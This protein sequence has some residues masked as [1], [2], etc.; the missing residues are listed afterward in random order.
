MA[1]ERSIFLTSPGRC[2]THWLGW[3]LRELL[4]VKKNELGI[5][6]YGNLE[7]FVGYIMSCER[8]RPGGNIYM[9]H[10]PIN[11]LG[12]LTTAGIDIIALIRDPRDV[13]VSMAHYVLSDDSK[14]QYR[15]GSFDL[16][17]ADTG[18]F[19]RLLDYILHKGPNIRFWDALLK[20]N[21]VPYILIKYEDLVLD[22]LVTA[23]SM[24]S[25]LGVRNSDEEITKAFDK[26]NFD[27]L[28]HNS[29]VG[30]YRKGVVGDWKNY[31]TPEMNESF[32]QK[33]SGLFEKWGY[34][35]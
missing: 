8:R 1:P 35:K 34:V 4:A 7:E 30:H 14:K 12:V 29:E 5:I 33:H 25:R 6:D 18:T 23:K 2:G 22:A 24:F 19:E 11:K 17:G 15:L 16:I 27:W 20:I 28:K 32:C 3:I 10:V 26:Y 31:L 13:A 21:S 9:Q